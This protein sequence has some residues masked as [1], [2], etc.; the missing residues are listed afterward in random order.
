MGRGRV[1]EYCT[2]YTVLPCKPATHTV[3]FITGSATNKRIIIN[4]LCSGKRGDIVPT[5]DKYM[6]YRP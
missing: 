2:P 6:N 4:I 1:Y 3:N 5:E